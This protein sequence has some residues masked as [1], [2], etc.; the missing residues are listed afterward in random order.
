MHTLAKKQNTATTRPAGKSD[1]FALIVQRLTND[2]EAEVLEFLADRPIHTFGIVGFIRAN[3]IVSSHN[4]GTFY[5][6]RDRK[7]IL[8]GVA[9]IGHFILFEALTTAA[10]EAFAR[11][12]QDCR[13]SHLLLGEQDRVETFWKSYADGGQAPRRFCSELLFEQRWPVEVNEEVAGLRLATIDDLDLIVPVHAQSAFKESGIDPLQVDAEA[14]RQRCARRIEQG[15]SWVWVENGRLI[16]KA[17]VVSDTED[18]AYLEG[19]WVNPDNR[20]NGIG[21]RCISHLSRVLLSRSRSICL[22]ANE[23]SQRAV[24]LYKKAGFEVV[25]FYDTIFLDQWVH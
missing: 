20:G 23:E 4:R 17:E 8:Q 15:R 24:S 22:L 21:S 25:G 16:F 12:A 11:L 1:R 3:G 7:G 6:C 13:E 14:F 5:A 9:L 19:V 10:I 18:V 2:H